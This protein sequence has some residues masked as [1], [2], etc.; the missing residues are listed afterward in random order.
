MYF[1]LGNDNNVI[2]L[3]DVQD[4]RFLGNELDVD[5]ISTDMTLAAYWTEEGSNAMW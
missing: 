5:Y 3:Y 1:V 2:T 4:L